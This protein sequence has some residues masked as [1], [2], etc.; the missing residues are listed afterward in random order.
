M[1][2]ISSY[3][4]SLLIISI[5]VSCHS[6]RN[7]DKDKLVLNDTVE[8]TGFDSC[9]YKK[10]YNV[11]ELRNKY[12]FS[13]ADSVV[14]QS[15]ENSGDSAHH[16]KERIV[17]NRMQTDSLTSILFNF[18]PLY[19]DYEKVRM[20]YTPHHIINFCKAGKNISFIELCFICNRYKSDPS[21]E[22][23]GVF[24]DNKYHQLKA[25]FKAAGITYFP[26]K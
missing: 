5:V 26:E 18:Q 20:C 19:P 24:C 9:I 1:K 10:M 7:A 17:L 22:Y 16:I 15:F 6:I 12:P 2:F 21:S 13:K 14:I 11:G 23:W 25:F 4:L 8:Y 3:L